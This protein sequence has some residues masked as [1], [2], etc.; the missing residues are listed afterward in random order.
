[1]KIAAYQAPFLP[2]GSIDNALLL[3]SRQVERCES[4]GVT[5]LC[6]PE[7]ILGGLAD[8]AAD[9]YAI[10]I[11]SKS[12]KLEA[13]L[14]PLKSN[15]VTT[16]IGFTELENAGTLYNSAAVFH[17]GSVIGIYRKQHP[18]I[19]RSVYSPGRQ[20]PIFCVGGLTFGIVICNDSNFAE[21]AGELASL[22]ATALFIPTNCGLPHEKADVAADARAADIKLATENRVWVIRADVAGEAD[23]MISYGSSSVVDPTG[24]VI[25]TASRMSE[26]LLIEDI[27]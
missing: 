9:R 3:V 8:Y 21:P 24:K 11:N 12:G 6:C 15:T 13:L 16:I 18:A 25:R 4:A 26:D 19:N 5:T 7:A 2:G 23:G 22:G 14:A 10:A 20:A 17:R 27:K 1:M